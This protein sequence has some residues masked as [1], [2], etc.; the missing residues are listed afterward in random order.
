MSAAPR[1][2]DP[3]TFR[4]R[5]LASAALLVAVA[6]TVACGGPG[7]DYGPGGDGQAA[8]SGEGPGHRPQRLALSPAQELQLGKEAYREVLQEEDH[9]LPEDDPRVKEVRA[10]GKR[11]VEAAHIEPLEREINLHV[12]W[13]YYRWEFN[14]LQSR[15]VNAFCLPGG[16]VAVYSALLRVTQNDDQLA[17]VLSHEIA[18][19]LAH[20]SSERLAR[21]RNA[22]RSFGSLAFQRSQE[23]E[24]DHIGVFLM[25]F[26]GYDPRQAVA[27]W[28]RMEEMTG[29]S[30]VPEILSDHPS[31]ERRMQQL[32]GWARMAM[33]AYQAYKSHRIAPAARDGPGRLGSVSLASRGR[34]RDE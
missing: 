18:H 8:P 31:D 19:A 16:K 23:S 33:G 21:E 11:I 6:A 22:G 1:Q 24:A 13:D 32:K 10:V 2:H 34:V 29:G 17:T 30:G 4:W 3:R 7:G 25:T 20:H 9:V 28:Q 14:V 27:F 5:L 15:K 26:A 12:D